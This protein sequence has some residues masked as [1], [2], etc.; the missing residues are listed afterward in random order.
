[1][2]PSKENSLDGSISDKPGI[3]DD[4]P[5]LK[6]QG[7]EYAPRHLVAVFKPYGGVPDAPPIAE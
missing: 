6:S 1:M 7:R 2:K 5:A 4:C 3:G